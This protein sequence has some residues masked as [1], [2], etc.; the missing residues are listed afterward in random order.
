LQQS[1]LC[2][3][4]KAKG[5]LL[6]RQSEQI[7]KT[8]SAV[9]QQDLHPGD[10]VFFNTPRGQATHVGIHTGVQRFIHVPKTGAFIRVESLNST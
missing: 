8:A 1:L 3:H 6:P 4:R 9:A 5:M 7:S 10:I 2:V